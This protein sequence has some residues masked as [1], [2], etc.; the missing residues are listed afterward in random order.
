MPRSVSPQG[1]Y[2]GV[3]SGTSLDA[4]DAVLARFDG[5]SQN[6]RVE[7]LATATLPF[8][9]TLRS[10]LLQ[11]HVTGHNELH[12]A[13]LLS[14][15]LADLYAEV[16]LQLCAKAGLAPSTVCAAGVH[17]QTVRHQPG[18]GYTLQ[19]N[20]PARIAERTGI[21][22]VADFR[23]RDIAAGGQGAPLVPAFHAGVFSQYA[24]CAV[25]NL[26][27]IANLTILPENA[28]ISGFDT[29]PGNMLMDAW[30]RKKLNQPFDRDGTWAASGKLNQDL[31][32]ALLSEPYFMQRPPKSTGRD[33]F[34]LA[35]LEQ[36]LSTHAAWQTLPP[37][38]VQAT[39]LA[40]TAH[41]VCQALQRAQ[42]NDGTVVKT[43]VVCGGGAYNQ[44]LWQCL[45]TLAPAVRWLR[46]D[47][48]GIAP[49]WVEATAFAWLT[50]QFMLGL[51]GNLPAVTGAR[52]ARILGALYPA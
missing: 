42:E 49:E 14:Q 40:L 36:H 2:A 30:I 4:A 34:H 41:S 32:D 29:G 7:I 13:A 23:S 39:L 33:Q 44:A 48:C 46:S 18:F 47:H 11:L 38:D 15:Q 35:W 3:M 26:G 28:D 51:P 31:L 8:T 19:L 22:V 24:P 6:T 25:L 52:G 43:M 10:H 27:G 16:L 45:N 12:H 21:N 17:G 1:L 37:E 50:R 9:E 5:T 20:Q